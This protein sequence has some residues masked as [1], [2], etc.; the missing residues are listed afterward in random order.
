MAA[1]VLLTDV[2]LLLA[3]ASMAVVIG[4]AVGVPPTVA[5]LVAGV[6][7]GPGGL[8]VASNSEGIEQ[9]ADI[10]VSL[11]LFGVGIELSFDRMRRAVTRM[12]AN[13]SV[14]VV[15]SVLVTAVGFHWLGF[16]WPTATAVGFLVSLSSTATVFKLYSERAE[17]DAPHGQAAA[18]ILF[19]QDLALVP[20]ILLLPVLGGPS[21]GV[22]G[23]AGFALLRAGVV[24]VALV[25]LA[26]FALPSILE[27]VARTR[28]P[29]LF[30]TA[31]L[32]LAFGMALAAHGL[33]LSLPLG[34]FLAGLALSGTPYAHQVFA[35]ILPLRDAFVALFFTTVGMLL[36]PL[37]LVADPGLTVAMV[38][39]VL[40]KGAVCGAVV[41]VAWRSARM[42][43]VA[44]ASLAQIGE[45]SFVMSREAAGLGLMPAALEQAFLG[46]AVVT[47]ML[48]PLM[49]G[50]AR[51]L[52][53]VDTGKA[54]GGS[55]LEDHVVV[56]GYGRT[57]QAIGRVL[58][59]TSIPF[60]ALELDPARVRAAGRDGVP[61]HFGDASRR[62]VLEG[63][64][65]SRCR[66]LVVA[67]SDRAATRRIV[68]V[69]RQMSPSAPI[70]ARAHRVA[71]I[72]EL[73]RLGASEVVPAEFEASIELFVRLLERLGIP[74]HVARVQESIIRL[75]NYHALRGSATSIEMLPEIERLFRGGT[76]ETA[77]VMPGCEA[78]GKTL[79]EL[80]FNSRTGAT[81]LSVVRDDTPI[82]SPR[83]ET[84]LESGD[85]LVVYGPHAAIVAALEIF[86]PPAENAGDG[87]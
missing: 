23:A 74:R 63:A 38:G 19:F 7:A 13:G 46:A 10:G 40:A 53:M 49:L 68:A 11:L 86:E 33:G 81:I 84:R 48:T 35:E 26:R 71:E 29:E 59:A 22:A 1:A 75:G 12:I 50:R 78:C 77:E 51:R 54:A 67:V 31:S 27:L 69:A 43:V 36:D 18:E 80:E 21:A 72:E 42:G 8:A 3:V 4:R 83:G 2:V 52:V 39:F 28:T 32:L 9:L 37:A 44:A 61:V 17:V 20:M 41:G 55:R 85:L 82:P 65:V 58:G 45:F 79:T 30:P 62:G 73:E 56:A 76:L 16:A 14:Q 47:M 25:V 5:Y 66:A 34:A 70:L 64:G 60:V 57:G 6:L 24:L 15:T 87:V